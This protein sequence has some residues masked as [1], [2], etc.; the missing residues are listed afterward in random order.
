VL[1]YR[2]SRQRVRVELLYFDGCPGYE[3]LLPGLE[4]LL[5]EAGVEEPVELRRVDSRQQAIQERFLGSPTVRVDG[6]DV[7]PGADARD[8]FGNCRLYRSAGGHS[9]IPPD[10]W[11]LASLERARRP[12]DA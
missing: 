6:A 3:S 12:A 11:I 9:P 1:P 10:E 7:E 4:R 5:Q 2:F 8:D